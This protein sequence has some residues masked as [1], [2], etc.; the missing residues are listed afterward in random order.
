MTISTRFAADGSRPR[1]FRT[2]ECRVKLPSPGRCGLAPGRGLA[3]GSGLAP[4]RSAAVGRSAAA[5]KHDGKPQQPPAVELRPAGTAEVRGAR[6][7]R[8]SRP[9]V[10]LVRCYADQCSIGA[11]L[12]G[13]TGQHGPGWRASTHP[14]AVLVTTISCIDYIKGSL[15][16]RKSQRC[17]CQFAERITT[18]RSNDL[19]WKQCGIK[20]SPRER[21]TS[22]TVWTRHAA[23]QDSA[24]GPGHAAGPR[25]RR[26]A[27]P[28]RRRRRP[29]GPW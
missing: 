20:T 18:L 15:V 2:C 29:T 27:R 17:P 26:W 8:S 16:S 22:G 3:P 24:A 6:V 9:D 19:T 5:G 23:G 4:G 12:R 11:A 7:T 25:L 21:S 14:A 10:P 13:G 28:R 1:T